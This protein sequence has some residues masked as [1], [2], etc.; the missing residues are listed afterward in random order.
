MFCGGG[1]RN[2]DEA[3]QVC[4]AAVVRCK[5]EGFGFFFFLKVGN[6]SLSAE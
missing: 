6:V 4:G 1:R 3:Q 2:Q 5:Y